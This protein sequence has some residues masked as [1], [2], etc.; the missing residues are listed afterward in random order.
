LG[1][2]VFGI[3]AQFHQVDLTPQDVAFSCKAR[4]ANGELYFEVKFEGTCVVNKTRITEI[5]QAGDPI[6][7]FVKKELTLEAQDISEK[8]GARDDRAFQK[9]LGDVVNPRK[10]GSVDCGP[11]ILNRMSVRAHLP[12]EIEAR[13][14]IETVLDGLRGKIVL[15]ASRGEDK[16]VKLL[17]SAYD[18]GMD[19][20]HKDNASTLKAAEHASAMSKFIEDL[21]REDERDETILETAKMLRTK[22]LS[23]SDTLELSKGQTPE[24][25][26]PQARAEDPEDLN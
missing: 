7:T 17:Q 14:E 9:D 8:Y 18:I 19:F 25:P 11:M 16:K 22:M 20:T 15:Y 26:K 10:G 3:Y 6:E 13:D 4:S 1:Q 5:L 2:K 12:D 23:R 21:E 24:E